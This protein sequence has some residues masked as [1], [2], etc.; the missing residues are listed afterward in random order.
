[1]YLGGKLQKEVNVVR[2][3]FPPFSRKYPL[4]CGREGSRIGV[5]L[6][7]G[8]RM[9]QKPHRAPVMDKGAVAAVRDW[10][11]KHGVTP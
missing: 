4:G 6:F 1:M 5:L 8:T 10:L 2:P 7:G 9:L 3:S 11:E